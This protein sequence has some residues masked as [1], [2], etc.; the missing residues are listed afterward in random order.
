MQTATSS[1]FRESP[2]KY[3]DQVKSGEE[4]LIV[5]NRGPIAVLKP[6]MDKPLYERL[7]ELDDAG[8]IKMGTMKLP[9]DFWDLPRPADPEGTVLSA[10]LEEREEGW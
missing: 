4:V 8:L 6:A 5:G 7:R 2:G 9:D 10:L 1:Q 3:L